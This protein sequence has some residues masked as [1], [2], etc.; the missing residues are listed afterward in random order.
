V[1]V[2]VETV[3]A[4]LVDLVSLLF[5]MLDLSV[6]LGEQY[7]Q[8]AVIRYTRSQ[9]PERTSLKLRGKLD[10][11]KYLHPQEILW[12][13]QIQDNPLKITAFVN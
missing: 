11:P 9:L 6:G 2:V 8:L 3:T 5:D 10:E 12:P 7:H 4:V 13:S 1:V